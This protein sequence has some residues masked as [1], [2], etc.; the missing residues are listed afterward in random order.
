MSENDDY[1]DEGDGDNSEN[2][3]S[4]PWAAFNAHFTYV[5]EVDEKNFLARCKLCDKDRRCP[6]SSSSNLKSHLKR[7]HH[8]SEEK[9]QELSVCSKKKSKKNPPSSSSAVSTGGASAS[10]SATSFFEPRQTKAVNQKNLN[11]LVDKL[12]IFE[13]LPHRIV[14]SPHFKA[15]VLFGVPAGQELK[16]SCRQTLRKRL[17]GHYEKM[18]KNLKTALSAVKYVATTA[19][20]WSKFRRGFLGMTVTWLD[21]STITRSHASL[22][23][24]RLKGRHT[25]DRL[26]A[27]MSGI[28]A[29]F[30]LAV[31]KL[32]KTITDSASNFRKA[33]RVFSAAPHAG[34]NE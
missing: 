28:H 34:P 8:W 2:D 9:L 3:E 23:L 11:E 21:P 18:V 5:K 29:E 1:N 14:D 16:I 20:G 19:D 30:D 27:A 26:A 17:N 32:A 4:M 7:K 33:F 6:V 31:P 22:A 12:V 10:S 15:A 25:H 13:N 24:R